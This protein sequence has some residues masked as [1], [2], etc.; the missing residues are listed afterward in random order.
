MIGFQIHPS[1]QN[2]VVLHENP[3]GSLSL[4]IENR[5]SNHFALVLL[6]RPQQKVDM[7]CVVTSKTLMSSTQP[8][9]TIIQSAGMPTQNFSANKPSANLIKFVPTKENDGQAQEKVRQ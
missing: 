1:E 9:G 8:V 7:Q 2:E 6:E 5:S 3:S 4:N